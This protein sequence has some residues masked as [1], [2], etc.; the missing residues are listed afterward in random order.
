MTGPK[1]RYVHWD[2]HHWSAPE[3]IEKRKSHNLLGDCLTNKSKNFRLLPLES[4]FHEKI[5]RCKQNFFCHCIRHRLL[6]IIHVLTSS[7]HERKSI[8]QQLA[9]MGVI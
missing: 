2:G 8:E 4:C 3:H 6:F 1:S 7:S 5:G 9:S